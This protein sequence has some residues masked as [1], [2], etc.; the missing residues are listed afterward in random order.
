MQWQTIANT[1]GRAGSSSSPAETTTNGRRASDTSTSMLRCWQRTLS[2]REEGKEQERK[3]WFFSTSM[4]L[5]AWNQNQKR[6]AD[7]AKK[8]S[9]PNRNDPFYQQFAKQF[10]EEGF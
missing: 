8:S 9:D 4:W 6:L 2:F 10:D 5:A 7:S 1:H 3:R